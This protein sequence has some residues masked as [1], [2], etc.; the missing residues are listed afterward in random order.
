MRMSSF[1]TRR[2]YVHLT[3]S[4]G[5]NGRDLRSPNLITGIYQ[6]EYSFVP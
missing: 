5:Y 1:K 2:S 3:G 6:V 4:W